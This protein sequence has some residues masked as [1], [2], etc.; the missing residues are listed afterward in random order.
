MGCGGSSPAE[1]E[2]EPEPTH[3]EQVQ[4]VVV[5]Q[6]YPPP[7]QAPLVLQQQAPRNVL[8]VQVPPGVGPGQLFTF[9]LP[10]GSLS[11]AMC[12]PGA[13]PGAAIPVQVPLRQVQQQPPPPGMMLVDINGD[14]IPD[15]W[16][17]IGPG[18]MPMQMAPTPAQTNILQVQVIALS[19]SPHLVASSP[20]PSPSPSRPPPLRCR[21]VA[22]QGSCS[23]SVCPTGRSATPRC[24]PELG[25]DPSSPCSRRLVR[26]LL[27][28]S[29]RPPA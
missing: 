27:S 12:P 16:R 17:P 21:Q 24:H 2:A 25:Q 29:R 7:Q 20:S 4:P 13:G 14:G 11:Q 10:D 6:H 5:Q 19:S 22:G 28:C 23:P 15:E 1:A 9:R 3:L 8:N 18:M 26:V